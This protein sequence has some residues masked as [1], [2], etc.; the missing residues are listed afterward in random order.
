MEKKGEQIALGSDHAGYQLKESIKQML[1]QKGY[2]VKDYGTFSEESTDYPDYVHP[3][4]E[5]IEQGV[6]Q[7]GII[8]CGSAN[9][10][11]MTANKHQGI[12]SAICWNE[13]LAQ[14]ARQHNDANVLALPARFLPRET[15]LKI[16]ETFLNTSFEGG[17][18]LRRVEKIPCSHS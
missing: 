2:T 10:V 5:A 4:A 9:G 15:A 7:Q 13:E 11:N 1:L 14:L 18:H 16:A 8:M 12:R 3:L 6:H 17:R